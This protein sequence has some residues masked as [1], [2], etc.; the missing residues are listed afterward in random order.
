MH[1]FTYW[2]LLPHKTVGSMMTSNIKI[3][4]SNNETQQWQEK[5]KLVVGGGEDRGN[6]SNLKSIT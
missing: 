1:L 2:S 5:K 3:S 6:Q 4:N